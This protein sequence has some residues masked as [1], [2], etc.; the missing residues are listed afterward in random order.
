MMIDKA[1]W[2]LNPY[3]VARFVDVE[4]GNLSNGNLRNMIGNLKN[5]RHQGFLMVSSLTVL[6]C[7][8]FIYH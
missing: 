3:R 5:A 8:A 2:T 1:T 7:H 4:I 6:K